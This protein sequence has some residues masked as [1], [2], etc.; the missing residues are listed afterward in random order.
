MKKTVLTRRKALAGF[1]SLVAASPLVA[2]HPPKLIGEPPGRIA[3]RVDL[4]NVLEFENMAERKLAPVVYANIAGGDR[5]FFDRITFRPRMMAPTT[6]LDL[7]I[8]LF[9][10]KMFAPL[11]VGPMARLQDYHPDGEVG[12]VRA[13]SAAKSWMVVSSQ[14]SMPIE[15]IA[16]ESKT[17]LWYQVFPEEDASAVRAKIDQAVK[18]GCKAICI[19]VAAP[20]RAAEGWPSPAKLVAMARPALN[21]A[22]I[23]QMRKGV[24]VPVLIKGIMTPQEADAAVKRGI[25][26]IV[27]S[28][29]GGLLIPGMASS[30]ETLPSIMEA[31]GG[32]APILIDGSFRRGSDIFKALAYGATAVMLGR[33]VVWGL[34]AYGPEGAQQVLEMLQTEVARDMCHCGR[35]AVKDIDRT[36]VKLHEA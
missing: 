14:A 17:T 13:A 26:G 9:G 3:P 16:A 12:M 10:E 29:Y 24:G 7:T 1:G 28:N 6:Q 31:V 11:M 2:D 35:P 19:T 34:A 4:V 25:D 21:W 36:V 23:D 20:I 18:A 22:A 5:S 33:P 30:M 32:K 15:K 27:V 8:S